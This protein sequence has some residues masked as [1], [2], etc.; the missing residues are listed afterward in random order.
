M[1]I[2]IY[3]YVFTKDLREIYMYPCQDIYKH[4]HTD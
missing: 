3:I 1:Y 4:T 2:Y